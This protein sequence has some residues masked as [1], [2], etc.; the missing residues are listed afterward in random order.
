M[1]RVRLVQGTFQYCP[2]ALF[3]GGCPTKIDYRK[4]IGYPYSNLSAGGPS[5]ISAGLRAR[6]GAQQQLREGARYVFRKAKHGTRFGIVRQKYRKDP[7]EM[8]IWVY[9]IGWLPRWLVAILD[10]LYHARLMHQTICFE[11]RL[12]EPAC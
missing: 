9:H 12:S 8:V 10:V 3:W 4:K 6:P 5:I 11:R 2:F 1:S 7:Y